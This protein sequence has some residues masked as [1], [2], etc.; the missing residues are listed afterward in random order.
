M[1]A[2]SRLKRRGRLYPLD[3]CHEDLGRRLL[4]VAMTRAKDELDLI[5]PQRLFMYQQ[6]GHDTG[7]ANSKMSRFIPKSIHHAF[8]LKHWR[9]RPSDPISGSRSLSR[10]IDVAASVERMWR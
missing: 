2:R 1:A 6:N 10:R 3:K 9:E 7:Y 8:E 5:V 4:H